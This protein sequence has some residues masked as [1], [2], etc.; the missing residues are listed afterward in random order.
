MRYRLVDRVCEDGTWTEV[1]RR[2]FWF[3]AWRHVGGRST[4]KLAVQ[5]CREQG[6]E[7]Q[8]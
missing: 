6:W 2:R 7:F 4:R 8:I 1:W 5:W 3:L